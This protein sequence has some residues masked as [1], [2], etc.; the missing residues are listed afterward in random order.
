M[1]DDDIL[2]IIAISES[3]PGPIAINMATYIGYM[4]KKVLGSVFATIGVVLPSLIIIYIISLFFDAF[5]ANQYVAY[6]FVGIKCAVAILII[7]AG[8]NMLKKIEKKVI[9]VLIF[10]SILI[11]S[12]CFDL[13]SINFSSIYLILIGGTIGLITN[14]IFNARKKVNE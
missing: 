8:L 2:E 14:C 12:I 13:F 4:Q 1:S 5:I 7:K 9:P 10:V 3:T 11:L 6:A